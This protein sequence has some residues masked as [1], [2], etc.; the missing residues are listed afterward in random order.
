MIDEYRQSL[1]FFYE[2]FLNLQCY[3]VLKTYRRYFR[4]DPGIPEKSYETKKKML[5]HARIR[6]VKNANQFF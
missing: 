3:V 2:K 4:I 1:I 5:N 6:T